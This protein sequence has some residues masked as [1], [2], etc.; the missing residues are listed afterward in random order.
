MCRNDGVLRGRRHLSAALSS[1]VRVSR[2]A[3]ESPAP[4]LQRPTRE[5]RLL[6]TGKTLCCHTA[7]LALKSE[8]HFW[9]ASLLC[10]DDARPCSHVSWACKRASLDCNSLK[11]VLSAVF[12]SARRLPLPYPRPGALASSLCVC[13]TRLSIS[14]PGDSGGA[15]FGSSAPKART[16][17]LSS[18]ASWACKRASLD[19]NSAK[20]ALSTVCCMAVP[21]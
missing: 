15:A 7:T 17:S 8:A 4:S 16:L 21:F 9:H 18:R 12:A 5:K 10:S 20:Y 19:S 11:Y 13:A 6:W 2:D 14:S 1:R 3:F